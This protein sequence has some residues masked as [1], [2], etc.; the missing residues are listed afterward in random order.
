MAIWMVYMLLCSDE[1]LYTGVTTDLHRRFRQHQR[2][3][4]SKYTRSRLPVKLV[5]VR[6]CG[7]RS[8]ALKEEA[9]IKR[10]PAEEKWLMAD[11]YHGTHK[12]HGF[13]L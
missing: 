4:A 8:S 3:R 9:R 2:G 10:L 1:S 7:D 6:D 5:Y 13:H 12:E 11:S